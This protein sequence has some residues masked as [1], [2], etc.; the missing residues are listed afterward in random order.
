MKER[1]SSG[2]GCGKNSTTDNIVDI[3]NQIIIITQY[4]SGKH[5][6]NLIH[7]CICSSWQ[8]VDIQKHIR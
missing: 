8:R 2:P 5:E 1:L 4:A 7:L 3:L 6:P